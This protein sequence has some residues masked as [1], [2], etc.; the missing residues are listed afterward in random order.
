MAPL[1]DYLSIIFRSRAEFKREN[2]MKNRHSHAG[3]AA[4][5]LKIFDSE[6][7]ERVAMLRGGVLLWLGALMRN[8]LELVERH[9][10]TM[11]TL[12]VR[13]DALELQ[14]YLHSEITLCLQHHKHRG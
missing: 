11:P 13:W 10:G 1:R 9:I 3:N 7:S 4:G 2:A 12:Q 5:I 6:T 14:V 8:N